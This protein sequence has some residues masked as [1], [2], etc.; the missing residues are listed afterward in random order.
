MV[1]E[2]VLGI[3][4]SR[5]YWKVNIRPLKYN[6]EKVGTLND[7]KEIIESCVVRYRGW[8]YP[9]AKEIIS[10]N[11][12]VL[13]EVNFQ[14]NVEYW[15]FYP[16][17]QFIH[18]FA[19]SEDWEEKRRSLFGERLENSRKPGTGLSVLNSL[20][21]F[22]E[23]FEFALRLIQKTAI[24]SGIYLGITIVGTTGRKLFFYD[25]ARGGETDYVAKINE[26]SYKKKFSTKEFL[27]NSQK[28]AIDC[29]MH[30]F[31]RFNWEKISRE[32]LETEQNRL[33]GRHK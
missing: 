24:E 33:I 19:I 14:D 6:K 20:Y 29:C 2:D 13:G 21:T 15:R 27:S 16:S 4:K 10:G 18:F 26:I 5:G 32:F 8:P 9:Y 28:H 12:Y 3:I 17:G 25:P 30:F 1:T 7:C 11:E 22:T 31:E 23:I